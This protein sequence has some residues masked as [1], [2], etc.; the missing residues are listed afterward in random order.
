LAVVFGRGNESRMPGAG[1][2]IH[3]RRLL[4]V[5]T[6]ISTRVLMLRTALPDCTDRVNAV[7]RNETWLR[8]T[9]IFF[10]DA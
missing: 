1:M 8:R 7:S 10:Y 6:Y 9:H 5:Y 3:L 4:T 2:P